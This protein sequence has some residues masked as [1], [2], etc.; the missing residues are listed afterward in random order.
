[1][2]EA[3]SNGFALAS[4]MGGSLEN[5]RLHNNLAYRN[6]YRGISIGINGP[7]G[8]QGQHP[9]NGI[10]ILNNTCVNNGWE[11]WGGGL[12][13]DNPNAQNVLIANNIFSQNR[14]FQLV[15]EEDMPSQNVTLDH[16]LIDGYLG[17]EGETFGDNP[18]R[19][20]A[21]FVHPARADF[22]LRATSPAIDA[23]T[24]HMSILTTTGQ[25]GQPRLFNQQ[26]DI[27]ADEAVGTISSNCI[28]R[29]A[30]YFIPIHF[31]VTKSY[32]VTV[33]ALGSGKIALEH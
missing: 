20:S 13:V 31:M 4:E 18:V 30:V 15:V 23:G 33:M 28:S 19:G 26:V 16:N 5:V 29:S 6:H 17:T 21:R 3:G 8:I 27:G 24:N 11:D 14:Y 25:D 7:G 22:H 32:C 2:H 1:V 10:E 12:A 9:M